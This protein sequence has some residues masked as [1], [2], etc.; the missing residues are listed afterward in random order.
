MSLI[1][2]RQISL[3]ILSLFL[4]S[5]NLEASMVT[6]TTDTGANGADARI[7]LSQANTNYG[8]SEFVSMQ[9]DTTT[10]RKTYLRFDLS[11]ISSVTNATLFLTPTDNFAGSVTFNLYGLNDLD[12]G[13]GWGESTITWN[14][15]PANLVGSPSAV[16]T[17][18]APLLGSFMFA[19]L[20]DGVSI[21]FTN[22][23]IRDFVNSDSNNFLTFILTRSNTGSSNLTFASK[24]TLDAVPFPTLQVETVP[25]PSSFL[26]LLSGLFALAFACRLRS[27]PIVYSS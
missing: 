13:E 11:S 17:L 15:A 22:T 4:V 16:D 19:G 3:C 9:N 26:L 5:S 14:N 25:E 2:Q 6:V 10:S 27:K 20:S 24:E 8:S 21:A 23:A 12:V 7:R 1:S 18:R